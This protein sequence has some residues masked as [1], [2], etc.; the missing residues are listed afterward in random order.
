MYFC[1]VGLSRETM[2]LQVETWVE[3]LVGKLSY[4][5]IKGYHVED[6]TGKF[7]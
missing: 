5:L 1:R 7:N 2:G 4:Y 3:W 6:A